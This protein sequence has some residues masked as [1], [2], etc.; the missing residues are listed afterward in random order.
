MKRWIAIIA[1]GVALATA[2]QV[3]AQPASK[4]AFES[5]RDGNTEIYAMA[6]DGSNPVNLTNHPARDGFAAWSP[7]GTKIAFETDRDGNQEIYVMAADGSNPLRL[8]S[9]PA[10]DRF[11]DWSPDGTKIAFETE[12]DGFPEVYVMAAD[13]SDPV[14]L[15]NHPARD[16]LPSWSPDGA[17]IAFIS[18]RDG[19]WEVYT[20]NVDGTDP[21][22]LTAN[23]ATDTGP[24]WSPLLVTQTP[25][26]MTAFPLFDDVEETASTTATWTPDADTWE[27]TTAAAHSG[28]RVWSKPP[29]G[30][31]EE[32]FLTLSA[33]LDLSSASN[34]TLSF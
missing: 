26:P 13:G 12:R 24:A 30:D 14:N 17:R 29:V 15:T 32:R 4:I 21:V 34:P 8:T 33:P 31:V 11:P 19:D 22:N 3:D 23:P 10:N 9:D 18:F 2:A 1:A 28:N 6:A 25:P 16:G 20:I 7:D 27:V 5:D